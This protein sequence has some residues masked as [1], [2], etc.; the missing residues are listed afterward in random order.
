[1]SRLMTSV[2]KPS[3]D[4]ITKALA[5]AGA[6]VAFGCGD[7]NSVPSNSAGRVW[8]HQGEAQGTTYTVKYVSQDSVSQA[9]FE[10]CLENVDLEMNAWRPSST[11]SQFNASTAVDAS[12]TFADSAGVWEEVW[13]ISEDVHRL[14][15]GAFDVTVGPLMKLWGFR[16]ERR[17]VVTP[18]MVD[19][20]RP[21]AHFAVDVVRFV[22]KSPTG[23]AALSKSDPRTELDFNAV[24]QGYTVDAMAQVLLDRGVT[25]MMVELGGEV[26]CL[27]LNQQGQP[28]RIAIDR[29]QEEGRTLQ[30]VLPVTDMSICTS[31]NYRKV[32][33]VNGQRFSHTL[34]PR[35]GAPVKHVLLSATLLAPEAAYADAFATA[36]MVLGPEAGQRWIAQMQ[37]QGEE[38]EALFIMDGT[39]EAFTY[40]ATPSLEA[41]LEWI[42]PLDKYDPTPA[43]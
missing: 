42:E 24:A 10:A 17:D 4:R 27:G 8:V 29:P 21:F 5:V 12:F 6:F 36:C 31:G 23:G 7:P 3:L 40:W 28:W 13:R 41:Q 15:D 34:D 16:M 9:A 39:G 25:N 20:V 38:V 37:A 14:S 33:V 35:T 11:L 30:A 32:S 18:T 2:A 1:M 19:S 26:K 43:E 22:P